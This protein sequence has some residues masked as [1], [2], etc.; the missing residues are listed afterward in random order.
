MHR[1]G[2]QQFA[3]AEIILRH[4]R[5]LKGRS[6]KLPPLPKT[7][8]ADRRGRYSAGRFPR[9]SAS[10]NDRGSSRQPQDEKKQRDPE[11]DPARDERDE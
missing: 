2:R 8:D 10:A 3:R 9:Q 6:A 11:F 7:Y 4:S 1:P 5:Q